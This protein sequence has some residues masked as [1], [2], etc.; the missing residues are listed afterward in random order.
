MQQLGQMLLL[1]GHWHLQ[2]RTVAVA[3]LERQ[4]QVVGT[5]QMDAQEPVDS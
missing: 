3:H 5:A 4:V 1:E 2:P